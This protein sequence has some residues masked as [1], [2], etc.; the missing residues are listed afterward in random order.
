MNTDGSKSSPEPNG[1]GDETKPE[2]DSQEEPLHEQPPTT[3]RS[4]RN[5]FLERFPDL[6]ERIERK[7]TPH[8]NLRTQIPGTYPLFEEILSRE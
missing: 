2:E 3:Y 1:A 8:Y 6:W 7:Y 5:V 4:V